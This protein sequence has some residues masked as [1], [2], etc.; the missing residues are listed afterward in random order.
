MSTILDNWEEWEK[1][2]GGIDEP[3]LV[4]SYES[5]SCS[6][7]YGVQSTGFMGTK[8]MKHVVLTTARKLSKL[9]LTSNL[10]ETLFFLPESPSFKDFDR[11]I[12]QT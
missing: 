6:T 2:L 5:S 8:L 4:S 11:K 7:W 10:R 9:W 12:A 3:F 1:Q